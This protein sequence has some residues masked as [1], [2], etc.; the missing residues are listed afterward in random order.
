MISLTG[1]VGQDCA[2]TVDGTNV[3][4]HSAVT[5]TMAS[6]RGLKVVMQIP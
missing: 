3:I 1:L 5:K 6:R 4:A 2:S